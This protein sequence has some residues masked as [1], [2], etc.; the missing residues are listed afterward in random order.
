MT[1]GKY[2]TSKYQRCEFP[3][4]RFIDRER[5]YDNH[6]GRVVRKFGIEMYMTAIFF[7]LN[8][9]FSFILISRHAKG[10]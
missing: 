6:A 1:L 10:Q 3:R 7:F 2:G 4:N 5:T 8:M 9:S